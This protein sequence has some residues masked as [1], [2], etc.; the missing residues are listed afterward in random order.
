MPTD[1][2]AVATGFNDAVTARDLSGLAALMADDHRFVDT[3]SNAVAGKEACLAAWRGFFETFPDYRNV[4]TSLTVR[5]DVVVIVGHSECAHP[6]LAGPA[7]W[8]AT[9]AG[10][11]VAEWHVHE[12]TPEVRKLLGLPPG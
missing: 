4:F 9:I 7:L 8:T 2:A 11:L 1:P 12:D 6:A 10:G 3:G 5:G